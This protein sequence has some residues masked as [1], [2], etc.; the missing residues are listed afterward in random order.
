MSGRGRQPFIHNHPET[1]QSSSPSPPLSAVSFPTRGWASPGGSVMSTPTAR[2]PQGPQG[3]PPRTSPLKQAI[4]YL[5]CGGGH[6]FLECPR[7]SD[8]VRREA[9][10]N[11][12]AYIKQPPQGGPSQM[13]HTRPATPHTSPV[14]LGAYRDT[15]PFPELEKFLEWARWLI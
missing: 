6:F 9:A 3:L 15:L 1:Q 12:E 10:A 5:C 7:L 13:A 11:R 4:C 2:Y 14:A 8:E